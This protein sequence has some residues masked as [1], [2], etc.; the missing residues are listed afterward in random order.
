MCNW[1]QQTASEEVQVQTAEDSPKTEVTGAVSSV[2]LIHTG[3]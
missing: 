2:H 1:W 3:Y